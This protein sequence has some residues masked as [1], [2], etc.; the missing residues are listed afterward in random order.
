MA[1][2]ATVVAASVFVAPAVA[3]AA[4]GGCAATGQV[5]S[6]WSS[7][8]ILNVTVANTS[9]VT[10]TQWTVTWTLG[11]GQRV[12][13]AWNAAVRVS[14]ELGTTV[15]AT[16]L[17]Y[18]GT[19]A[20]GA[21]TGF[22]MQLSGTGPTP[23]MTCA[24]DAVADVTLTEADSRTTITVHV[25]QTITVQLGADFRPIT[26]AGTALAQ[27]STSG[28]YP[29]GQPLLAIFRAVAVGAADL[30][31]ITDY[32]CLHDPMFPCARPQ[33]LWTVHVNV[34]A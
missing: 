29:T 24:S 15:T 12:V 27:Q 11:T 31:T 26:L 16:N 6:Q 14:G 22:G 8:Q 25:G 9:A 4:A 34:I 2:C 3:T 33:M 1:A 21:S 19:L 23:A 30:N 32:A 5:A 10:S 13:S 20:P 7:G 18:N 28:G 17:A